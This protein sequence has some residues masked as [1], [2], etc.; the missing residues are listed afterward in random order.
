MINI[1]AW[2][3]VEER[4]GKQRERERERERK[5]REV[6]REER[7]RERSL[8]TCKNGLAA[9]RL[10]IRPNNSIFHFFCIVF[11]KC[12]WR[13]EGEERERRAVRGRERER[14]RDKKKGR[15]REREREGGGRERGRERTLDGITN[16]SW[17]IRE[18]E[19]EREP[20]E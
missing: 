18:I 19:R 20:M 15:E 2:G 8:M 7:K 1:L 16:R 11:K 5:E 17:W 12:T 3:E 6:E 4:E 13:G 14:E 10:N 9:I